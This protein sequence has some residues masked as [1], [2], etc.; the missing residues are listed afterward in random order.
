M[1]CALLGGNAALVRAP[2]DLHELT[3]ILVEKL[4]ESDPGEILTRRIFLAAF[5][6]GRRD[7]HEA[8]AQAVDGAMIWGGR[9]AV[10]QVRS[11]PFSTLGSL[12]GLRPKD[13]SRRDG[14]CAWTIRSS[15]KRGANAH[16]S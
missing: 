9:E 16:R 14:R 13:V 11:L 2:R 12:G 15:V 3:Q 7:L 4:V 6:H 8:M 1:T 5:E 10:L